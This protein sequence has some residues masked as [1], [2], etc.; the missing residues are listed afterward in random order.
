MRCISIL[1]GISKFVT[2]STSTMI[3]DGFKAVFHPEVEEVSLLTPNLIDSPNTLKDNENEQQPSGIPKDN[4]SITTVP[5]NG[6]VCYDSNAEIH[7]MLLDLWPHITA[8]LD[9]QSNH[10]HFMQWTN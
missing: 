3:E 9:K 4:D 10:D 2:L 7:E 1:P 8:V 6:K 5:H